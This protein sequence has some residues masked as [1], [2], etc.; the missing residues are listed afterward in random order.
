MYCF[1]FFKFIIITKKQLIIYNYISYTRLN[2][3]QNA[4]FIYNN[5]ALFKLLITINYTLI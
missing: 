3:Q 5:W 2:I 1:I 4:I